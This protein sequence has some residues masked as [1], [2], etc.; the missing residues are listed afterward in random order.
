MLELETAD[1]KLND[2]M[3]DRINASYDFLIAKKLIDY[4]TGQ[5]EY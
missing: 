2:L 1:N 5:L 4:Y 3:L